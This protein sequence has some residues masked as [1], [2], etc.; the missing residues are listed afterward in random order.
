MKLSRTGPSARLAIVTII[1]Y[2]GALGLFVYSLVLNVF[3]IMAAHRMSGG[4]ASGVV[5]IPYGVF[6]V[7][8]IVLIFVVVIIS[9]AMFH[10]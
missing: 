3:S 7:L 6:V 9:F 4:R 10:P 8:Y 2:L 5:L 1:F